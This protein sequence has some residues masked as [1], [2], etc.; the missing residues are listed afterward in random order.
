LKQG[1]RKPEKYSVDALLL[2]SWIPAS[3][4]AEELNRHF[5]EAEDLSLPVA[6]GQRGT[7]LDAVRFEVFK[8]PVVF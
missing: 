4:R 5:A 2:G 1:T 7:K 6:G 8:R 3:K